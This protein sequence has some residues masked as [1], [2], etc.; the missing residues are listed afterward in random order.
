MIVLKWKVLTVDI[1]VEP[2]TVLVTVRRPVEED[3]LALVPSLIA[4]ADVSQVEARHAIRW[5]RR[6]SRDSTFVTFAT[7]GRIRL[8]PYVYWYLLPLAPTP[9]RNINEGS[10]W[11]RT[12]WCETRFGICW[13]LR[14]RF[15]EARRPCHFVLGIDVL[16][17]ID[18]STNMIGE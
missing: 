18:S 12:Y 13:T 6:N 17:F 7:V 15:R 8:V 10:P 14:F 11:T 4:L 16:R 9:T 2:G 1:Q 3:D 5:I